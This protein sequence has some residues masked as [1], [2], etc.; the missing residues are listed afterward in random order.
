[1]QGDALQFGENVGIEV[2]SGSNQ[3]ADIFDPRGVF[4]FELIRNG[5][6]VHVENYHNTVVN[7]GKNEILSIMFNSGS[8]ITTWYIGLIDSTG[9]SS[10]P[11]TDTMSSHAGWA[12]LTGYSDANR[13][14]WG[15]GAPSSQSITN[16]TPATFNI[17]ASGSVRGIFVVSNNTKGG[18]TGKLWSTGVFTAVPIVNGDQV[19]ITYTLST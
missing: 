19:K 12:E 5:E 6:V 2:V 4:T 13:Q 10:N 9:Y 8:Q 7:E 18:T 11:A 15:V 3:I 17:N 1:M 16:G 14:A